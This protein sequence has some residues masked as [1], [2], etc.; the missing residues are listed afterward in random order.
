MEKNSS[1][2]ADRQQKTGKA[3]HSFMD[4]VAGEANLFEIELFNWSLS[5]FGRKL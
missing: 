5:L 3:I 2:H 1:E 4:I